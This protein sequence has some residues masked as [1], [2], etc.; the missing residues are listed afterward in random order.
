MSVPGQGV[1]EGVGNSSASSSSSLYSPSPVPT[2]VMP[3]YSSEKIRTVS[4]EYEVSD[5]KIGAGC[6]G[7]VAKGWRVGHPEE[8]LAVKVIRT[9]RINAAVREKLLGEA[10]RL[11]QLFRCPAPG[12]PDFTHIV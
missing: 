9:D 2:V 12:G 1:S 10:E 5:M 3:Q 4:G 6:F 8:L 11:A 7:T